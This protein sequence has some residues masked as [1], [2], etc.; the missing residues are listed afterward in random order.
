MAKKIKLARQ[1]LKAPM[2]GPQKFKKSKSKKLPKGF[3]KDKNR[4]KLSKREKE[5]LLK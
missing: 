1:S 4:F 3:K 5:K 2:K